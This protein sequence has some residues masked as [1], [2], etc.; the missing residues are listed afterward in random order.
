MRRRTPWPP[1]RAVPP[2][3]RAAPGS[4]RWSAVLRPWRARRPAPPARIPDCPGRRG[5]GKRLGHL[6]GSGRPAWLPEPFDLV[7][8]PAT[9][10]AACA[11]CASAGQSW[12]SRPAI[13]AGG[14]LHEAGRVP[15]GQPFPVDGAGTVL[16]A[17]DQPLGGPPQHPRLGGL[18]NLLPGQVGEHRTEVPLALAE[19]DLV[20]VEQDD[21]TVA[22]DHGLP[23]AASRG[24]GPAPRG[25][26]V[27]RRGSPS[28]GA[29][30]ARTPRRPGGPP[31]SRDT[32]VQ[33]SSGP[34]GDREVG[35]CVEPRGQVTQP[36]REPDA[37]VRVHR[38]IPE[39]RG[40]DRPDTPRVSN[41]WLSARWR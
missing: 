4:A 10:C 13:A 5:R 26:V 32:L 36:V 38:R 21:P 6:P 14:H 8:L 2:R 25:R 18:A 23:R 39:H 29:A 40:E 27:R 19:R 35:L 31:P 24:T 20:D 3:P 15:P 34:R 30:A 17:R 12:T 41:V 7:W 33:W 1:P 28:P 9:S 11:S 22:G 16:V 37:G